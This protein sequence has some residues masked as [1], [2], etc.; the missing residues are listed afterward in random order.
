MRRIVL[1]LVF[2]QAESDFWLQLFAR[3]G[4][5]VLVDILDLTQE[6]SHGLAR[7]IEFHYNG[8]DG[9]HALAIRLICPH[10]GYGPPFL[11]LNAARMRAVP[12]DAG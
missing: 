5:A 11:A 8:A 3:E 9:R 7:A 1:A 10:G 6:G 4:G 12:K 2:G